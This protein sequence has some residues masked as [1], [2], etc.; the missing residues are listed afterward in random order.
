MSVP[1]GSDPI[2]QPLIDDY[3]RRRGL[4]LDGSIGPS[5]AELKYGGV[6]F[7]ATRLKNVSLNVVLLDSVS[8]TVDR[9]V[10]RATDVFRDA[11]LAFI[12]ASRAVLSPA[13]ST[14]ILGANG[15]LDC[16]AA[17]PGGVVTPSAEEERLVAANFFRGRINVYYVPGLVGRM[18][19][20]YTLSGMR[21]DPVIVMN[22]SFN[23]SATIIGTLEHELGHALGL[24]H[25]GDAFQLMHDGLRAGSALIQWEIDLARSSQY[26]INA[27]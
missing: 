1:Y 4:P 23:A 7:N 24:D 10:T 15:K 20:G 19:A 9:D 25:R 2:H 13:E 5:D 16:N 22:Q 18:D 21:A 11:N 14:A 8:N 3:R 17:G 12:V 6:L 27:P 26:A